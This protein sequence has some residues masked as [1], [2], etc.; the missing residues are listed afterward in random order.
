MPALHQF[1]AGYSKGDAISNE[2]VV[3]RHIFRS[4]GYESEIFCEQKRILPEFRRDAHDISRYAAAARPDDVA[5]LHLSIGS[6]SNDVFASLKCGKVI[7]YHN[8]TPA[9]YFRLANT[10]TA[11][12]LELG[13][14]QMKR[15]A[16]TAQVNLADSQFNADELRE[17][18]YADVN[19]FPL[20]LDP[21]LLHGPPDRHLVRRLNDGRV[22]ILFVGRCAPN[23]AI[24]SL[25][26]LFH[27]F[28]TSV[29]KA[30][31]LIHV[32]SFAGTERY[33][34]L[35]RSLARDLG[36]NVSFPGSV[37]QRELAAY[38]QTASLFVCMSEH[39]GFCIPLL[40]AMAHDVPVI[41]YA[42]G[43][44]P[45]TL[46]GAGVLVHRKDPAMVAELMGMM[47]RDQPLRQAVIARQRERLARFSTRDVAGELRGLLAPLLT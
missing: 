7:L 27:H 13:R 38:Y 40:E 23:K 35:I 36:V 15:L 39:E 21:D 44:V 25:L 28:Q 18:G 10:R 9:R 1:L 14:R 5:L 43:A 20:A 11:Q 31:R 42:A 46:D 29:E 41:A 19:V 37:P 4:W 16:G 30:S 6:P 34:Y 8:V 17:A 33:Y 22:N 2:S 47:L 32:G 3:L 12:L 26:V 24:E 45:E